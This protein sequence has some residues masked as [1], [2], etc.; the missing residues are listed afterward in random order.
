MKH[1][2]LNESHSYTMYNH[3]TSPKISFYLEKIVFLREINVKFAE[4]FIL[5]NTPD[6]C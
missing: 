2:S 4:I 3:D 1:I 6:P 5:I